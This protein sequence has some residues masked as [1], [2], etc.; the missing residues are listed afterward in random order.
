MFATSIFSF[1]QVLL[2]AN[3]MLGF[4]LNTVQYNEMNECYVAL[5][6]TFRESVLDDMSS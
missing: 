5:S 6:F 1:L 4:I 3:Q 2:V